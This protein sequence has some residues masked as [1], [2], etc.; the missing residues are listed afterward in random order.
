MTVNMA[1]ELCEVAVREGRSSRAKG[2]NKPRTIKDK[3][4]IYDLDIGPK[5]GERSV[6]EVSERDLI[7]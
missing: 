7:M 1:H 3:I 4:D 2:I 5:L 6:D